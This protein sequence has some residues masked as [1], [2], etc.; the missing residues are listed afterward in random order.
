MATQTL[1]VAEYKQDKFANPL[2]F[3]MEEDFVFRQ[4]LARELRQS[5]VDVVEFSDSS[6]LMDMVDDQNPDIVLLNLDR[7]APHECVRALLALKGSSYAGAVQLFGQCESRVLESANILGADC[8]LT[9]L[10]PLQKPIKVAAIHNIIVGRRS[11]PATAANGILLAEALKKNLVKFLYQPQF[12]LKTRLM[13]GLEAVA[14]VAHPEL[15]LLTPD[16]FLKGAD[17]E[18]LVALS[19]LALLQAVKASAHFHGQGIALSIS[20]NIS[21]DDL[22]KIPVPD[23]VM[24]HRPE[25]KSWAGLILEVPERQV[26]NRIDLLK[27]R[28]AKLKYSGVLIAIDNFGRTSSYLDVMN[29]IDFA[30]IKIDR[31]LV[32]GCASNAGNRKICKTLIQ[33][34][35]NFG[36]RAVAVGISNKDDLRTLAELECDVGQGFL[37]GKPM[38]RQQLDDMIA[39][40]KRTLEKP[41]DAAAAPPV[42]PA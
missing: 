1:T 5:G 33:M 26:V 37:L 11:A 16:L 32:E 9:M 19:R 28:S 35:H 41:A 34:A 10:V 31:A 24:L 23:V 36:S 38:T 30:E 12:D 14:R 8:A 42:V 4:G 20:I 13:I 39:S 25:D 40:Y 22:L 15:G 17:E 3:I 27:A 6:R 2:C 7:T 21:V 29:K 18:A